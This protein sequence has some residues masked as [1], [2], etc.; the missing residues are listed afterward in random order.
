MMIQIRNTLFGDKVKRIMV[1]TDRA[2]D[3]I[4][5]DGLGSIPP[6]HGQICDSDSKLLFSAVM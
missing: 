3:E 6:F 1:C 5:R 4:G 2:G